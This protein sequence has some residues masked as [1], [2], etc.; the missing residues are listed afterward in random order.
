MINQIF[1][2]SRF[3][4]A[5]MAL[6]TGGAS[7]VALLPP[8]YDRNC[9]PGFSD[10]IK[11]MSDFQNGLPAADLNMDG[12]VNAV[13][14]ASFSNN[15]AR[16]NYSI[17]WQ[18]STQ[19]E[20]FRSMDTQ[21]NLTGLPI[22]RNC[23][24]IYE[25][26]FPK[27]PI[28]YGE[29]GATIDPGFHILL[30]G[31]DGT[32]TN[33][34]QNYE[35]W[36]TAHRASIPAV[37]AADVA[38]VNFNGMITLDFEFVMPLRELG[39]WLSGQRDQVAVWD[40]TVATINSPT[41]NTEF[42]SF[43]GWTIPEGKTRWDELTLAEQESYS[44][45]AYERIGVNYYVE[46]AQQVKLLR[47]NAKIGYYGFPTAWWPTYDAA[48]SGYNDQLAPLWA[49]VD[50]LQPSFY[51][52]YYTTTDRANSPCPDAVNG[53]SEASA[54]YAAAMDEAYRLR[55]RWGRPEQ[56]IIPFIWWHYKAQAGTCSP[57]VNTTLM[58]NDINLAMQMYMPWWLGADGVA[59]WGH[60]GIRSPRYTFNWL[61]TPQQITTEIR[62]RWAPWIT[63]MACPR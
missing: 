58:V 14:F 56:E 57:E 63:K 53:P 20:G 52:L 37:V 61:D 54:F 38:D 6:C 15:R 10:A 40:A 18:V 48:R 3:R 4:A 50:L 22:S 42:V 35:A 55:E 31:A 23:V 16:V 44:S 45:K 9:S 8:D 62:T 32:Y 7:A 2:R 17:Y 60:Y 27:I 34:R 12:L 24:M 25:Q 41:I 36:M 49:V 1:R 51:Q 21:T 59:F 39:Y 11:F 19:L 5:V 33:W 43:A 46:T 30:R 26:E 47:P 28:L 13:D 29:N